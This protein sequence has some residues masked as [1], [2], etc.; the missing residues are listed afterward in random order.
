MTSGTEE[1]LVGYL[2]F[3]PAGA[4]LVAVVLWPLI[5]AFITGFTTYTF[6]FPRWDSFVWFDNFLDALEDKYFLNSLYVIG[7]FVVSVVFLEFS[8]GFIIAFLLSRDI[9]FKV[10][11]YTILTI[12]MVMA[13]VAVA[14]MWRMFLHTE[15]GIANYLIRLIGLR[16]VN[17]LGSSKIAFWTVL[18]VDIWHQIS[19]MILILLAGLVSLPREPY[20]AAAIDGASGLQRLIY[21]TFP[22]M[23]P[24]IVIVLLIRTIFAFKT[25]DL[26]YVLTRGGPGISTDVISYYIYRVTFSS[27]NL[28]GGCAQAYLFLGIIMTVVIFLFRAMKGTQV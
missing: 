11:F 3:L 4:I 13:P 27:L 26:I 1:R 15:L 22:L 18:M 17:W 21:I 24:V 19:F 8:L 23:K 7:K 9:K 28:A 16:P 12:P 25:F 20:E 6:V 2:L 14:L 5:W 10:V